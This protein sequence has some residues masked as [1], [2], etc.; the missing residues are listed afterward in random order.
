MKKY[1]GFISA[2]LAL[3]LSMSSLSFAAGK[4]DGKL[5]PWTECGIGAM[6]FSD[7]GWAAAISNVIWD[8][9]TT[10]S[11]TTSSSPDMCEGDTVKVA[12]FINET[13]NNI[14]EETASGSGDHITAALN[15]LG[16]DGQAHSDITASVR[17]DFSSMIQDSSYAEK[18]NSEKAEAYYF[19]LMDKVQGEFAHQ[20]SVS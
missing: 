2:V 14:A 20:C 10:A 18:T 5:N 13:Y 9:G 17:S 6:I 7:T 8:L 1:L 15:V 4:G 3:T 11:T 16:C 19:N 12:A